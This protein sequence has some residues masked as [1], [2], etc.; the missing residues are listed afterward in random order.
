MKKNL[1]VGSGKRVT[2]SLIPAL[3]LL[4]EE[5]YI[6][7]RNKNSVQKLISLYKVKEIKTLSNLQFFFDKILIAIPP[8]NI[9]EISI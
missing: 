1:I 7:A 4:N 8:E 2:Q 3:Q 9:L 5:I 6:N